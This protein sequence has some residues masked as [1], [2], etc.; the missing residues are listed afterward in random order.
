MERWTRSSW[1]SP[2]KKV[3]VFIVFPGGRLLAGIAVFLPP[4]LEA[5]ELASL[6]P[7]VVIDEDLTE[8]RAKE[9]VLLQRVER[10]SKARRKHRTL[11]RVGLVVARPGLEAVFQTVEPAHDL[12]RDLEIGVP[13]GV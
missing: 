10:L 8:L 7:Q 5:A 11:C 2:S 13:G 12:L 4:G 1:T 6:E 9:R 3:E